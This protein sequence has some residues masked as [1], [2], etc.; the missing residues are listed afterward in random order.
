MLK[1]NV[2]VPSVGESVSEV[3]LGRIIAKEGSYV[4]EG[5]PVV[6]LESE[7]ASMEIPAPA[8]GIISFTAKEGDTLTIGQVFAAID[9]D[10]A[11]PAA[12]EAPAPTP[13]PTP[14]NEPKKAPE[15]APAVPKPAPA[16][17]A[18]GMRVGMDEHLAQ[19]EKPKEAPPAPAVVNVFPT[20]SKVLL[21]SEPTVVRAAI[22]T[23]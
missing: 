22:A 7:K 9:S 17:S 12:T 21:T 1:V 2:E 16:P 19:L 15:K 3:T 6:E 20:L 18:G 4:K 14:E 23:T 8:S 11:A 5:D 13:A 10:A